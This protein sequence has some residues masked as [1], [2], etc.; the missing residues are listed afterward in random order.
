[1]TAHQKED[2]SLA[3]AIGIASGL[4]AFFVGRVGLN[5]TG[6]GFLYGAGT[7]ACAASAYV[8]FSTLRA[9]VPARKETADLVGDW[10]LES[11]TTP[12]QKTASGRINFSV[13][14]GSITARGEVWG[15]SGA[16]IANII[17]ISCCY[18][19][20]LLNMQYVYFGW[21]DNGNR[22]L[23]ECLLTGIARKPGQ[24]IRGT[25][26]QLDGTGAGTVG[27]DACLTRAVDA[28]TTPTAPPSQAAS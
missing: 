23:H 13:L 2:L 21:D 17:S 12:S 3:L 1:M 26:R 22:S 11:D 19:R 10:D 15:Q 18:E 4:I 20:N 16:L 9:T 5:S 6:G 24:Y 27:G 28:T 8:Y 7:V 14:Q 25:W